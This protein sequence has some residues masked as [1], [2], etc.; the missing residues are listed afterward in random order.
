M[1]VADRHATASIEAMREVKSHL[2]FW[3]EW[4]NISIYSEAAY[5]SV[6]VHEQLDMCEGRFG[7]LIREQEEMT[8]RGSEG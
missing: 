8:R 6:R 2:R 5:T 4:D 1:L 7:M 3:K